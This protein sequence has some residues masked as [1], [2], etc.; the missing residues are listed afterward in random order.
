M[1]TRDK[2]IFDFNYQYN[3]YL[4][5]VDLVEANMM[6]IQKKETKQAFMAACGIML[7]LFRDEL[8]KLTDELAVEV[9]EDMMKQ[10]TGFFLESNNKLN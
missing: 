4:K 8:T 2:D 6:A 10:I 9:M 7:L 5:R 3:E 1:N